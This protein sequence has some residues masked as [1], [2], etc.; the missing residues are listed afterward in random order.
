[1][2]SNSS[3]VTP[4]YGVNTLSMKYRFIVDESRNK[5][6]LFEKDGENLVPLRVWTFEQLVG[7]MISNDE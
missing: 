1:M 5:I 7:S 2:H 3:N 6:R 4:M